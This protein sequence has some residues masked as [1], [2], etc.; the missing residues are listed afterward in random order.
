MRLQKV[1][2]PAMVMHAISR[3][4]CACAD[5]EIAVSCRL[6]NDTLSAKDTQ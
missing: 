5:V 4:C 3:P 1:H 2:S 6:T